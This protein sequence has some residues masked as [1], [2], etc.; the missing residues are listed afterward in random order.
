MREN[1]KIQIEGTPVKCSKELHDFTVIYCGI[2]PLGT[3]DVIRWCTICGTIRV[4]IEHINGD[5]TRKSIL[6]IPEI[7][8]KYFSKSTLQKKLSKLLDRV[9]F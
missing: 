5:K 2:A 3:I 9:F 1:Q 4:E 7:S 6:R 8:E